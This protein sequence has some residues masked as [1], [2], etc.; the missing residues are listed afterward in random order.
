MS[1]KL[2]MSTSFVFELSWCGTQRVYRVSLDARFSAILSTRTNFYH[3][4]IPER[5][6]NRLIRVCSA[7]TW[8]MQR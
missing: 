3:R 7:V 6:Y 5:R 4:R 1:Q 8:Q 2:Q